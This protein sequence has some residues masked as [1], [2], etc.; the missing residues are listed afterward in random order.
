MN[1]QQVF[2]ALLRAG[3]WGDVKVNGFSQNDFNSAEL[4]AIPKGQADGLKVN[5]LPMAIDY[6]VVLRLAGEQ[7]VVGL[8]AA[9][10]ET[11]PTGILPLTEKLKL[12]GICQLIEQRNVAM[13]RFITEL[14]RKMQEAG[15]NVVLV[16]GQGV[17]QCYEKPLWR[18]AGD[19][20][21]MLDEENYRKAKSL[22]TP[23]ATHVETEDKPRMH[24]GMTFE[25]WTVEL[26]GTMHTGVSR[27]IN[28]VIDEVQREVCTQGSVRSWNNG[29]VEV[30]LP[31][32]GNDALLIFTHFINHFYGSGIGLRQVC[33]WCRLLW[34]YREQ[35]DIELL[36]SR[37]K[38][39]G[40][41]TTWK[42][43]AALSVEHLGMTKEAMP[44]YEK[45]KSYS[46]KAKRICKFI[47]ETGDLGHNKDQ[48]YRTKY[49]KRVANV[50]T[51]FRRL[52]EFARIATIFPFDAPK[53]FVTYVTGRI[54]NSLVA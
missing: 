15:I 32:P 54:K 3:L 13:N 30:M 2:L 29:G 1:N 42:A 27:R 6:D 36:Q 23:L 25:P 12:V 41:L 44:L 53:F 9:G 17:A 52:G 4:K 10:L 43:F 50:V 33:D 48:S 26:H 24:L 47:L 18:A 8:V 49:P 16:K 7:S 19:I 51:F 14:V 20:D 11:L 46:R 31:N 40:L 45:S 21:F 39:M 34:T 38:A 37:L 28:R 22:L 35:I 5:E